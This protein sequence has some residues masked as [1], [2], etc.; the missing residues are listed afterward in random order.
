MNMKKEWD[1]HTLKKAFDWKYSLSKEKE[2]WINHRKRISSHEWLEH[3][4][5]RTEWFLDWYKEYRSINED[6]RILH[7]GSGAEGEI[8][9]IGKGDR[10]AID[11]L[12]FFYRLHFSDI[13]NK[14]VDYLNG[15]GEGLPFR[16]N[17][18]DLV[19]SFNSLDHCEDPTKVLSEISRVLKR[20]GIFYLGIHVRSE[21][22][23]LIFEVMKKLRKVTD[24]YYGYT[25]ESISHE[26][27]SFLKVVDEKGETELEKYAPSKVAIKP[28]IRNLLIFTVLDQ[29]KYVFHLLAEKM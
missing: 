9:F 27:G 20:N 10:I 8:N 4:R 6:S 16:D 26:V 7:I 11:P 28:T 3:V 18:F 19:I 14:D 1:Q 13:M 15:R 22:G 17:S 29:R 21:Y 12:V 24:H 2:Y 23:H 25:S 5:Q